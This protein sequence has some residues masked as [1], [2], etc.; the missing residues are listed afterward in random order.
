MSTS[1]S[2]VSAKKA[3]FTL[4]ELLVVI[5][6]IAILAAILFPVFAKA[7]ERAQQT[8]CLSNERQIGLGVMQYV[9]DNDEKYPLFAWNR[10]PSPNSDMSLDCPSDGYDAVI[11]PYLKS[12]EV[13][14]CPS[15]RFFPTWGAN[16]KMVTARP[17]PDTPTKGRTSYGYNWTLVNLSLVMA[18][19]PRDGRLKTS[20]IKDPTGTI[21]LGENENGNHIT[22]EPVQFEG[23]STGAPSSS[24]YQNLA[25]DPEV[26]GRLRVPQRHGG[27]NN[28]IFAD[29]HVRTLVYSATKKPSNMWSLVPND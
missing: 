22:Y 14:A 10:I 16:S 29:G 3:G 17:A 4:I 27:K 21:F 9:S 1:R 12:W 8:T 7:R 26:M 23:K 25:N 19:P 2:A 24:G 20:L 5:A 13:Y 15:Q 11:R 18:N 28:Y 6:I